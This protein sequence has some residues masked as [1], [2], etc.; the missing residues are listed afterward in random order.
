MHVVVVESP[1]KAKTINKY[2]G[3]DY[4]V[5]ASYGHIRDLPPKDGSVRP[6]EGFA[7]DWEIDAKS[8]KHVKDI[9]Q[10]LKSA[11]GLLLATDPDREGEAISWHVRDVLEKRKALVG[12]QVQRITFNAITRSAVEEALRNPRDLDTPLVEAYLARRALD[13]LVGFTLSPVLWRKLPGSRS[14]GRVQSVAL[15]LICERE[16]EVERFVSREYWTVDAILASPQGQIFRARL[17]QLDGQKLD[18]FG[19]PDETTALA[20]LERI[21]AATLRVESVERKQARRNP[22]APFTTSTIQQEASRKL[23]F[24]ARQTMQVAQKLYEG[25]DLGGETVGLITYMRTDGVSIAPEAVFATRDLIGAEFGAAYLPEQPRVYK[26]KAKNA[27]EAHEAIRP[28]DVARTPQSVAPYL[29]AEQRKLYELVWK[30]T[31]ASQMASA[32]LDQVAVD[33]ADPEAKVVLHATGSVIQFDGFLKVYRE[34]FDDRPESSPDGAGEDENRLLPPLREGDGVKREDVKADQHFT[35]PPPRYTEASLVK[36]MEELGIGRPSTYASILSV[37]QDREYV[38]LDARR[39]IPEDRGR[40]VTAFLENFFS[41]YV[42]YSFTADLE[43]QLD[44]ISDGK[45]GWK[46]VLERFWMDFKAAIEGT[47]TLRVSEVLDA[48]DKELG[49]HLFPQAEDGHDPRVCPVCSAGRLGL[50]IGKFGAFVGCSNYPDCKFTRPL[51]TKE[52]EGGDGA[53]LAEDGTKPLGK[54]PVSGEDV[55]LRK[56]PYGLYVQKGEAAPVEKGKKAVKPPRVSIP[57]D[58]DAATIDLDIALK[59]LSLPR[60]VGD[61]P[62]T[63][64]MISAGIGRFGPYIKHGDIYK[65]L[66]KDDDVL[67]IGLNRAVSL[68]AEAG[69]GGRAR[70]P[71]RSLGDHPADTKPVTIHDGRFGPYVQHG[72]VRATIPRTADPATY[73]LAEAVELIAAKAAKDGDGKKAPAKKAATKAPVKKAAAEKKAPAKTATKKAAPKKAADSAEDAPA[74]APRK[75]KA[76][77]ASADPD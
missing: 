53:A 19:L 3:K 14:A 7:M 8:E 36:R 77:P 23:Y 54:D 41:R 39:F 58:M 24:S 44:E 64:T 61:H 11:D 72:G 65:S 43:N 59:L 76:K 17:S 5:L 52:G 10:A 12:K 22:A 38:R 45:L 62:E 28:T 20:A 63:G 46:T 50:R 70:Q 56:G 71:A 2:L 9:T 29:T 67:T 69:K 73:T 25:V 35:Q 18:K 47:A 13:Y 68:L 4:V 57:K 31:V 33:I 27:Q 32:I 16:Q 42:Q 15:R 49:P 26:T 30:R 51:V 60:P 66:P 1:A 75:S 48:L 74:K 21:K 37:L 6:D 55:T 40:L 34:D